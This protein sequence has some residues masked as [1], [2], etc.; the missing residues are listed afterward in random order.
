[1]DHWIQDRLNETH[2]L[3]YPDTTPLWL[4]IYLVDF[5]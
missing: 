3:H 5:V 4:A 2:E 1:M